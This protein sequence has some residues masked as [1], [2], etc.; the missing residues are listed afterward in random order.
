MR[1]IWSPLAIERAAEEAAF[2]ASDKPQ[3]ASKWLNGL[4]AAVD[5]LALFPF[6]GKAVPEIAVGEYRQLT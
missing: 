1:I 3:A 2:I 4:F 6:A 5:R